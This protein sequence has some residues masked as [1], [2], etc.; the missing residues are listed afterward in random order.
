MTTDAFATLPGEALRRQA[1]PLVVIRGAPVA[2]PHCGGIL[3]K[4]AN[5]IKSHCAQSA[6]K[7][8]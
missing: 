7:K 3:R 1:R 5:M 8:G 2:F 4:A 6:P